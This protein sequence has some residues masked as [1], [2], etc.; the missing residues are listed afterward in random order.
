MAAS[1]GQTRKFGSERALW[2]LLRVQRRAASFFISALL[3]PKKRV[4]SPQISVL[5][6]IGVEYLPFQGGIPAL[7]HRQSA[8]FPWQKKWQKKEDLIGF[9]TQKHHPD[10]WQLGR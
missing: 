3:Q 1:A 4:C 9:A 7:Q 5:Q 2:R 10:E 8:A 6:K